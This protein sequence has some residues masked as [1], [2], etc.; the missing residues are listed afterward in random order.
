M[1]NVQDLKNSLRI[2]HTLD[3]D[4]LQRYL[5]TAT[6][7]VTNAV[8]SNVDNKEYGK[9]KQFDFAVS[10]LAQYWYNNRGIELKKQIPIE[11]LAMIQQL[12]G[13]L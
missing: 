8:N 3:D 5:D 7:Y 13:L 12:R 10:L 1:V 6:A 2:T 4:L 9:Y 11:V